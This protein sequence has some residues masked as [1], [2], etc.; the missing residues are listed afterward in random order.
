MS[1]Y[2]HPRLSWALGVC[3]QQNIFLSC[4]FLVV[5]W[6]L[7]LT[8]G[9]LGHTCEFC[10]FKT[11]VLSLWWN[12]MEAEM[13]FFGKKETSVPRHT[14]DLVYFNYSEVFNISCTLESKILCLILVPAYR[15]P[16]ACWSTMCLLL[17]GWH[18]GSWP[19]SQGTWISCR[20]QLGCLSP[21]GSG[22]F[23]S[24]PTQQG[25]NP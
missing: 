20:T 16:W 9:W 21:W 12:H 10:I 11:E 25:K 24:R 2:K 4:N 14:Q 5:V 1:L 8:A 18:Q 13:A 3:W 19:W 15:N 17:S 7:P 22:R 6:T 23:F